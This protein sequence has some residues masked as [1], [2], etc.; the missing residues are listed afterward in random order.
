MKSLLFIIEFDYI[1]F[2]ELY[3]MLRVIDKLI[4]NLIIEVMEKDV[5]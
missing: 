4:E 2:D 1:I 5:K 3:L